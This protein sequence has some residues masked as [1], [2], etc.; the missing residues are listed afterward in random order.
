MTKRKDEGKYIKRVSGKL[1]GPGVS[2]RIVAWLQAERTG[3]RGS[4]P[5]RGRNL[6]PLLSVQRG[7]GA[8]PASAPIGHGAFFGDKETGA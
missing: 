1:V 4:I 7:S 6:V 2:V 8:H 5:D 3:N